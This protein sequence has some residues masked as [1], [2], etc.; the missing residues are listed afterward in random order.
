MTMFGW[1]AVLD[2]AIGYVFWLIVTAMICYTILRLM[3]GPRG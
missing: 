2:N 1:Q 3:E